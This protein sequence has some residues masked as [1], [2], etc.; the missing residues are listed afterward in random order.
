M[1]SQVCLCCSSPA[2]WRRQGVFFFFLFVFLSFF[3]LTLEATEPILAG[4][5]NLRIFCS[6][7]ECKSRHPCRGMPR[8]TKAATEIKIRVALA[9]RPHP[10]AFFFFVVFPLLGNGAEHS[11]NRLLF[12]VSRLPRYTS[13]TDAGAPLPFPAYY[14]H[15]CHHLHHDSTAASCGCRQHGDC[16]CTPIHTDIRASPTRRTSGPSSK[17]RQKQRRRVCGCIHE[18]KK[19][20]APK[21]HLVGWMTGICELG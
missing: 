20:G 1:D 13:G 21:S 3:G 6:T 19:G 11:W 9:F 17:G 5:A 12:L 16:K 18:Q 4:P 10:H 14:S 7:R 2:T 15:G 8:R